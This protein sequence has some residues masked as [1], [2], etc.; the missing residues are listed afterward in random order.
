M[1]FSII[2][3]TYNYENYIQESIESALNQDFSGEY[4]I[5]VVDDFSTDNTLFILDGYDSIIRINNKRN[6]SLEVSVNKGIKKATG[7]YIVRLDADDCLE[8]FFLSEMYKHI[9]NENTFYYGN[10]TTISENG[11]YLS[12][13]NLIDFDKNEVECRGDFLAT[14]TIYPKKMLVNV[15]LYSEKIKNCGLENYELT[16]KLIN[17]GFIGRHVD[18]NLFFIEGMAVTCQLRSLIVLQIMAMN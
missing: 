10:Y 18:K 1:F 16:L 4:E 5:I 17:N 11:S 12:K 3:T 2:I 7:K 15:G 14:G 9:E 13:V 8:D 6:L